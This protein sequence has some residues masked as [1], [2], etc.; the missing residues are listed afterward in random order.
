[1]KTILRFSAAIIG[2]LYISVALSL[3]RQI[4]WSDMQELIGGCG[5]MIAMFVL[6]FGLIC[7]SLG[8]GKW[9]WLRRKET[10]KEKE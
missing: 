3:V 8:I 2:A 6:G 1:M 4:D 5:S 7:W 10:N 9:L